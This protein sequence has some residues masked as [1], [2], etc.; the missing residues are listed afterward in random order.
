MNTCPSKCHALS[1]Q[2]CDTASC[3]LNSREVTEMPARQSTWPLRSTLAAPRL[4]AQRP[5]KAL[6]GLAL[7]GP[8]PSAPVLFV[9]C[10]L[11]VIGEST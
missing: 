9:V 6:G 10:V 1:I 2:S 8:L 7:G 11:S 3:P 5:A 4:T